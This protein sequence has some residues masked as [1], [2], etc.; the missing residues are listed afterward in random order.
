MVALKAT[1][2]KRQYMKYRRRYIPRVSLVYLNNV[3]LSSIISYCLSMIA[4]CT[5]KST[6]LLGLNAQSALASRSFD[7]SRLSCNAIHN[8]NT[9]FFLG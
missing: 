9:V 4:F 2:K 3:M 6:L 1:F 7:S 5:I 8:A